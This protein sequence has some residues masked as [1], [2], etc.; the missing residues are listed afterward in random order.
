MVKEYTYKSQGD[1][2]DS[3]LVVEKDDSGNIINKYM[4]Y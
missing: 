4:T 2:R 3:W 1:G